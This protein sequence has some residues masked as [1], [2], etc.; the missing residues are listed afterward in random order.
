MRG[1]QAESLLH[2]QNIKGN[3]KISTPYI[4]ETYAEQDKEYANALYNT[5]SRLSI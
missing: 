4:T 2:L 1:C 3:C 5:V